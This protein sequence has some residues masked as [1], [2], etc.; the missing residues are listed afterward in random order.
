MV[1][2]VAY[3]FKAVGR[4]QKTYERVYGPPS[5]TRSPLWGSKIRWQR[6]RGRRVTESP[7]STRLC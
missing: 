1:L 2:Q 3:V 5:A 4:N 6:A 7:R